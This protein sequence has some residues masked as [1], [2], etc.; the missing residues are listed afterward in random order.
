MEENATILNNQLCE[1]AQEQWELSDLS[2][3]GV[4]CLP[5]SI[6]NQKGFQEINGTCPVQLQYLIDISES[7]YDQL[8][9]I[10]DKEV[11]I[12]KEQHEFK[13]SQP[14]KNKKY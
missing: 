14:V 13:Q 4:P 3:S 5:Q 12:G 1:K 8:Q 7:A 6:R 9:K 11:D 10:R 2:D